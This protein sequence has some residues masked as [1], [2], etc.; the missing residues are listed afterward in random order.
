LRTYLFIIL[1]ISVNQSSTNHYFFCVK[2]KVVALYT[3]YV[4]VNTCVCVFQL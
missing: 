4:Y 1:L 2:T 3:I